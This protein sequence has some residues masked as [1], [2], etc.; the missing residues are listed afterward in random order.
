MFMATVSLGQ[1]SMLPKRD[2]EPFTLT[3][4]ADGD[5]KPRASLES[6]IHLTCMSLG[7]DG[8]LGCLGLLL[9]TKL[10][11]KDYFQG[12]VLEHT[13]GPISVLKFHILKV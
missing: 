8:W 9:K 10:F 4:T 12:R 2:R 7:H 1:R 13:S 3:F 5:S 11:S 6:P